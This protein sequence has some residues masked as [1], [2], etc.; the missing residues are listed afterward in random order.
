MQTVTASPGSVT[1]KG[2]TFA[3]PQPS[4]TDI[5]RVRE[6]MRELALPSCTSPLLAVNA[7]AKELDPA[8]LQMMCA[9]AVSQGAGGGAEPTEEAIRR[10]YTTLDGVRFQLWYFAKRGGSSATLKEI[11]DLVDEEIRYDVDDAIYRATRL[12]ETPGPKASPAGA[13]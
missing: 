5:L 2:R 3:I 1:I 11:E 13:G 7:V 6:K 9:A 12:P 4:A 8:V 10:Q